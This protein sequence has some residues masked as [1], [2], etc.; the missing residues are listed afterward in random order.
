GEAMFRTEKRDERH[1]W[2]AREYL[3]RG[4]ALI[5]EAG[6]IGNQPDM[7]ATQRC[8]FLGFEDIDSGLHAARPAGALPCS[9]ERHT[10]RNRKREAGGYPMERETSSMRF[11]AMKHRRLRKVQ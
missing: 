11:P 10:Y 6:V 4:A 1:T 2:R 5:V 9:L 7:L 8:K 3:D